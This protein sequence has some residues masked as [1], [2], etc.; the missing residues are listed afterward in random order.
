MTP[1]WETWMSITPHEIESQEPGCDYAFG[2]R[3]KIRIPTPSFCR[4][5]RAHDE[6]SID[7]VHDMGVQGSESFDQM[8]MDCQDFVK[9]PLRFL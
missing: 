2:S 8:E 5:T 7:T 4:T 3:A 6:Q 9:F 1:R